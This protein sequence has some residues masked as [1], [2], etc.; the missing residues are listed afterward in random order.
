MDLSLAPTWQRRPNILLKIMCIGMALLPAL[1]ADLE[2]TEA[3]GHKSR[4]TIHGN[5]KLSQ[6]QFKLQGKDSIEE[7][8]SV[9]IKCYND[10]ARALGNET[11]PFCFKFVQQLFRR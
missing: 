8:L 11:R 7:E 1:G 4:E 10:L 3:S 5:F 9:T 6:L 2:D